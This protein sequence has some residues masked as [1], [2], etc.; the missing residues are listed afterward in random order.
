MWSWPFTV[1]PWNC[2]IT[3]WT[4][5]LIIAPYMK[6]FGKKRDRHGKKFPLFVWPWPWPGNGVLHIIITRAVFVAYM[7]RFSQIGMM[8]RSGHSKNFEMM[9]NTTLP[10][11]LYL[12]HIWSICH[13]S[14]EP[15]SGHDENLELPLWLW[16]TLTLNFWSEIAHATRTWRD[17]CLS[18][19]SWWSKC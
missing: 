17:E 14:I 12:S 16:L 2:V 5:D 15:Q 6:Q 1:L 7:K 11:G 18:Q 19:I 8:P 13:T 9:P 3:L 4:H 10:H